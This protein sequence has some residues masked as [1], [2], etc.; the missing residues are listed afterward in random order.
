[1]EEWFN[2]DFPELDHFFICMKLLERAKQRPKKGI[3]YDRLSLSKNIASG[4][5]IEVLSAL[6]KATSY[7]LA[8]GLLNKQKDTDFKWK[9]FITPL[10]AQICDS[11]KEKLHEID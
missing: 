3:I 10:G 4:S 6:D 2:S 5:N 8:R 9:L 1:M 11:L 7:L